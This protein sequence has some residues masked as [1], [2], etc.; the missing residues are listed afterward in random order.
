MISK[1][2]EIARIPS[3]MVAFDACLARK[4]EDTCPEMAKDPLRNFL[5]TH[6]GVANGVEFGIASLGCVFEAMGIRHT[7]ANEKAMTGCYL[8][9][10]KV[11]C[12]KSWYRPLERGNA[13]MSNAKASAHVCDLTSIALCEQIK[14]NGAK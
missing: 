4:V 2:R 6:D 12:I 11:D 3:V 1:F 7:K 13:L 14:I 8:K 5:T 10:D 9:I